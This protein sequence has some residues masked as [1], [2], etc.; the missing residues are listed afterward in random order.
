MIFKHLEYDDLLSVKRANEQWLDLLGDIIKSKIVVLNGRN[1]DYFQ[2]FHCNQF[3]VCKSTIAF[4]KDEDL[5]VKIKR[6]VLFNPFMIFDL[7]NLD[8][9]LELTILSTVDYCNASNHVIFKLKNLQSVDLNFHKATGTEFILETPNLTRLLTSSTVDHLSSIK[10]LHPHSIKMV[11][12][13]TATA[14]KISRFINLEELDCCIFNYQYQVVFSN[15]KSLRKINMCVDQ[16]SS[17]T[18]FQTKLLEIDGLKIRYKNVDLTS[19]PMNNYQMVSVQHAVIYSADLQIYMGYIDFI[20]SLIA[21]KLVIGE[22]DNV[23]LELIRKL[24][25]LKTLAVSGCVNDETKWIELLSASKS[26]N[27]II[28]NSAVDLKYLNLIPKYC[29]SLYNLEISGVDCGDWILELK[30]LKQLKTARL[31][32]FSLF[33]TMTKRLYYLKKIQSAGIYKIES[34]NGI[35]TCYVNDKII[36]NEPGHVFKH[37][38]YLMH[39]WSDLFS[40]DYVKPII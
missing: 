23:S 9:L 30:Y 35:V 5:R 17:N 18:Y 20:D 33:K 13:H 25:N 21:S 4:R 11:R 36:S 10:P 22:L 37:T 32:D 16:T 19:D 39:F 24:K 40:M 2:S 26:L 8:S 29:E 34:T 15:L 12:C 6:L 27:E 1:K 38:I 14:D 3:K 31:F 7:Q 28:I